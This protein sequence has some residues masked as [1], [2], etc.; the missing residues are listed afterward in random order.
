MQVSLITVPVIFLC[1]GISCINSIHFNVPKKDIH[2]ATHRRWLLCEAHLNIG[3]VSMRLLLPL[4]K[5]SIQIQFKHHWDLNG[6]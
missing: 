1:E 6:I 4:Q 2:R 3:N 5:N